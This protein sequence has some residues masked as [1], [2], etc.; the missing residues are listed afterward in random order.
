MYVHL[1][2][3][4]YICLHLFTFCASVFL[5]AFLAMCL[6]THVSW[7]YFFQGLNHD[8]RLVVTFWQPWWVKTQPVFVKNVPLK[9]TRCVALRMKHCADHRNIQRTNA[10]LPA[11]RWADHRRTYAR[12]TGYEKHSECA[13]HK[14]VRGQ[15]RQP[16]KQQNSMK[17]Q[18]KEKIKQQKTP[19]SSKTWKK[20][21]INKKNDVWKKNT[22]PSIPSKGTKKTRK[23]RAKC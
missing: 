7:H 15:S 13:T 11:Q 19:K 23:N 12:T 14:R 21:R 16:L 20:Q 17:L 3:S 2:A 22:Y 5:V 6:K 4:V 8:W 9:T 18:I 10:E 1:Y